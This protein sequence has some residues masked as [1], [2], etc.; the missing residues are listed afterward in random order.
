MTDKK[1]ELS[2]RKILGAAGAIGIA[3]AGAGLGTSALFSDEESF[4][5]NSIEAGEVNLV[6]DYETSV[7]QDGV[8]TGSTTG[9]SSAFGGPAQIDGNPASKEYVINDLKPGDS[10]ELLFCPK[11]VDNPGWLWVGSVDGLTGFENGQTEP[12]EE[13]DD[14]AGGQNNGEGQGELAEAIEVDVSYINPPTPGAER[15]LNN[16]DGYTLADLFKELE[17][18][19]LLDGEPYS[20]DPSGT[21]AYPS[22]PNDTTQEG[23][24]LRIEWEVPAS[25]GNEIQTDSLEFDITFAAFQERNNPVPENPFADVTV[26]PGDSIQ[27]AVSGASDDDVISV[28]GSVGG[29]VSASGQIVVDKSLSLARAGAARPSITGPGSS[30]AAIS[31]EENDVTVDGFDVTNPGGLLGIKVQSGYDDITICNNRVHDVGPTGNLGVTGIIVGQGDHSN[32]RIVGN[33][34]EDLFQDDDGSFATLNGILFDDASGTLTD[35]T[36]ARNIIRDS[37]STTAPLGIVVQP[38]INNLV[39]GN[40]EISGLTADNSLGPG[41]FTTFAQGI[42]IDS[43][44]TAGFDIVGNTIENV[45]S[46]DGFFGEDIKI[47]P[48][49]DV[50]GIDISGNNLLSA[51]GLNNANG[52]NPDVS[53]ENNYWGSSGGPLEIDNNEADGD[54]PTGSGQV[55]LDTV[56]ESA[57]TKNVDSDP[58]ATSQQ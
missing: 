15:E 30:D 38:D 33:I 7:D 12:E 4:E 52:A 58:F 49:S 54:V 43:T 56:T 24:C 50:S 10:G 16:P 3:G 29:G 6:V 13:V 44:S 23:P 55:D 47:E 21:Q 22:S 9:G 1:I 45:E 36:V 8:D 42:S 27:S 37:E 28:H 11:I 53:A 40:N 18:G 41:S 20:G 25:V 26:G 14:S 51:I 2:R 5:N 57:V 48:P 34:I 46:N 35:S 32:I 17:S 31:I 19:F 39:I